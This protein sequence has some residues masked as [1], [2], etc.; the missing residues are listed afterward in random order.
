MCHDMYLHIL[1]DNTVLQ[2]CGTHHAFDPMLTAFC[3]YLLVNSPNN[4]I[5]K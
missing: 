1:W 5:L 3:Q 4:K 2:S